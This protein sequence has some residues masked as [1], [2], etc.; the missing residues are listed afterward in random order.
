[1]GW[2]DTRR[3]VARLVADQGLIGREWP[4][5]NLVGVTMGSLAMED[6]IPRTVSPALPLQA[7]IRGLF[8]VGEEV[9]IRE[10]GSTAACAAGLHS[11]TC[12]AR[13]GLPPIFP[14]AT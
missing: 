5:R 8:G 12:W 3:V 2:P 11:A 14:R 4:V 1:M 9:F 10:A 7:S 13:F 6:A